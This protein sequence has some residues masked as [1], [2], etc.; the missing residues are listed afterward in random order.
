[1]TQPAD[2]LTHLYVFISYAHADRDKAEQVEAALK[3]AGLRVFRDTSV[4][5]EGAN[6]DMTIEDALRACNRMVLLLS[7][8]TM[9]FRKEV[10]REWFYFDQER[11]PLYPLLIEACD[12]HSRLYA[13]NYIDARHDLSAALDR[14]IAALPTP[15]EAPAPM[16]PAEGIAVVSDDAAPARDLPEALAALLAAIRAPTPDIALSFEQANAI[17]D[18]SPADLTAYRLGRIAEWALP[19]YA[20][21]RRFVDLTLVLDKGENDPMRWQ[22]AERQ[23]YH[24]LR[25]VLAEH[26]DSPALAVLGQPGSGKSTLLRRLQLD[27]SIDRLRAGD[28]DDADDAQVSFFIQLNTYRRPADGPLPSPRAWLNAAWAARYPKMPPLDKFLNEGRALL[29]LDALN[30]MPHNSPAEYHERVALWRDFTHEAARAG[31]RLVYSCRTLDYGAPLSGPDLRVPQI[32]VQPMSAEQVRRFLAAYVPAYEAQVWGELDGGAGFDL[33]Q[34]PYFLKL[35]CDQVEATRT[36]PKGRAGLFTGFVRQALLREKDANPLFAPDT[37]LT[38]QDHQKLTLG[39]WRDAFDLPERGAL[40]PR[41]I[42]LA[43]AMQERGPE[44]EGAQVRLDYAA[45]CALLDHARDADIVRA[46][47][48]LNLLDEDLARYEV[49]FFHQLLQEY[50]AARRLAATPDPARVHVEWTHETA[51]PPL[52]EALGDLADGDP[53][54][55]LPQTGWEESILTAAP[56]AADPDAFVG[57][58]IAHNLPLAGRCAASPEVTISPALKRDLQD[59]LIARSQDFAR[60]D[61]RARIAAG[62]ALGALGDPRFERRDGPHG[63]YLMPPLVDIPAGSYPLGDD[64]SGYDDERPAHTVELS[65]FQIGQFPVTNAEYALFMAAGG[66]DDERWWT[67]DEARAWLRGEA[68]TEGGK[69]TWR[70]NRRILQGTTEEAIRDLVRQ[71]RITSE[72]AD[73]WITI[74]NWP[75]TRFEQQLDEWYPSGK[76]FRQ[77]EFWDDARFNGPSRPVVGVTWFEARAY[78]QWLSAQMGQ[79]FELPTEAQ[80]EAAARGKEGRAYPYGPDFDAARCNAFE[81]HIRR[82]TPVGAFDNATPEGAFDLAGNAYTWTLSIYDQA[83]FLYPYRVDERDDVNSTD[84]LRVLRGGSWRHSRG[85]ARAAYRNRL[86]PGDRNVINGFRLACAVVPS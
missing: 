27:H 3:A 12:R 5:R 1:M 58:L 84:V 56:M 37:L 78:C 48:A 20:L 15:P 55:S 43:F 72:Q 7:S 40:L 36:I 50:F 35:L 57:D 39:R 77:P 23:R 45:A 19:R 62:E 82:T 79:Q 22:P 53:L 67:T 54:P 31:N 85:S 41:L 11:K 66:Y 21:D 86:T 49:A 81:S 63:A 69:I 13:Y 25:D 26:A 34:T 83:R 70:D 4:I 24:D 71:N 17:R 29:L 61:V 28:A 38:A 64:A 2:D 52:A 10:H 14:L 8:T 80:F 30:E 6:W 65:A 60:A 44:T 59:A 32:A 74:R 42:H 18:H 9:P 51:S 76:I 46:G 16:T 33:Y 73:T 68:S 47:V 75:E